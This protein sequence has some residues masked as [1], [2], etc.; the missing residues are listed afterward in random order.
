MSSLLVLTERIVLSRQLLQL[1]HPGH[2]LPVKGCE[3][4]VRW[5]F[6]ALRMHVL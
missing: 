6:V 3:G 2:H 1:M 4:D 5:F